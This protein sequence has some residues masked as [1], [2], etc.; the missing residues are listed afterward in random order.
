MTT[1][2]AEMAY[3]TKLDF[4]AAVKQE[5]I[6]YDE[7]GYTN[8]REWYGEVYGLYHIAPRLAIG[9][10]PR[11]GYLNLNM[12]PD[13]T[14]QQLLAR[15]NYT[16]SDKFT[17]QGVVG[18]EDRQYDAAGRSDS[19]SPIFE[20]SGSY[21]PSTET[22]VSF[23]AARHFLPSYNLLGENYIATNVNLAASQR[24]FDHYY[25]DLI[26]GFENDDYQLVSS[27]ATGP[28]RNDNYFF[29]N[30]SLHWKPNGWLDVA[31][32]YKHEEDNS[33]FLVFSYDANQV[34]VS[35]SAIY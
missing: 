21:Q 13:E 34:G 30:P 2:K 14:F 10:G 19:L 1:L 33:N 6:S 16:V 11:I 23:N 31:T 17:V 4:V 7:P 25:F 27:G 24:F 12:A 18:G 32:F 20:F 28:A 26:A 5:F 8:S 29:I 3:S 35:C 15:A 9:L 22:T